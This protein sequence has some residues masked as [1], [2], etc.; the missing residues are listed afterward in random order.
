MRQSIAHRLRLVSQPCADAGTSA[1]VRESCGTTAVCGR[2][3]VVVARTNFGFKPIV[4][5]CLVKKER[6]KPLS[7]VPEA[8]GKRRAATLLRRQAIRRHSPVRRTTHIDHHVC[9]LFSVKRCGAKGWTT[10]AWRHEG[11][12]PGRRVPFDAP[13]RLFYTPEVVPN[14]RLA[15]WESITLTLW[16]SQVQSLHRAPFQKSLDIRRGSSSY[17]GSTGIETITRPSVACTFGRTR[18]S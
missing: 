4:H 13:E 16:G 17:T 11:V 9:L 7:C 12:K 1:A 18:F 8:F 10:V 2:S 3:S 14:A 6:K 15:Q 5:D